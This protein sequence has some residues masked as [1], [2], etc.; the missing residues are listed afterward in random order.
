M[1]DLHNNIKVLGQHVKQEAGNTAYVA[2]GDRLGFGAVE[3][4]IALGAIADADATFTVLVEDSADNSAWA[5]VSDDF[6][7]GVEAM[8]I[9]F[10]S[11]N[12]CGKIGY[13]GTKRYVRCTLT[14]AANASAMDAAVVMIGGHPLDCPHSTQLV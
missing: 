6:L 9:L 13:A 12:K 14:P 2:T 5:A 10:S 1:F 7:L 11:D 8:G 4:L 3:F